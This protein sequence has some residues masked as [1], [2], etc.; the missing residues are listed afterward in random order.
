MSCKGSVAA[1]IILA[2]AMS[3]GWAQMILRHP[4]EIILNV[5]DGSPHQR[6]IFTTRPERGSPV[7]DREGLITSDPQF[8]TPS[9]IEV[10][11]D[12]DGNYTQEPPCPQPIVGWSTLGQDGEVAL[13]RA[14]YA[15][16][17]GAEREQDGS[18]GLEIDC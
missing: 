8:I 14:I 4:E 6:L 3:P 16:R 13:G 9:D 12:A 15:V 2:I 11:L 17:L 18:P 1:G 5:A 10:T 7:W